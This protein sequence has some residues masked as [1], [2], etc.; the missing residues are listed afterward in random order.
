MNREGHDPQPS[1]G[2]ADLSRERFSKELAEFRTSAR[3]D[4]IHHGIRFHSRCEVA[5]A[6]LLERY[7]PR[8]KIKE[9]ETYQV[10]I[11][12]GRFVDFALEKDGRK[13][14]LEYHPANL[15]FEMNGKAY[16]RLCQALGTVEP[17]TRRAI[18]EAIRDDKLVDYIRK[19]AFC[20]QFSPIEEVQK[21]TLIVCENPIQLYRLV[22]KK[23][24]VNVPNEKQFIREWIHEERTGGRGRSRPT[25][26]GGMS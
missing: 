22:M 13:Y 23:F 3:P 10:P 24:G 26:D 15:K 1:S 18:R 14:L 8:F 4:M 6:I 2:P 5:C 25:H 17:K 7:V 12:F 11:G 21:C 20:I 16:A 9:G 19:R